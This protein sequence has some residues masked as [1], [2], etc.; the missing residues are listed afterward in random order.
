MIL[1]H[2]GQNANKI[3]GCQHIPVKH[4]SQKKIYIPVK[5]ISMMDEERLGGGKNNKIE[6]RE[7]EEEIKT[8]IGIHGLRENQFRD[9]DAT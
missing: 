9:K 8:R 1:R 5:H 2:N 7:D 3:V 4:N 6:R